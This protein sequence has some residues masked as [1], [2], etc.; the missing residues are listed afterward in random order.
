[1]STETLAG[2]GAHAWQNPAVTE[3]GANAW[4]VR[5]EGTS[6]A[7]LDV[8]G[9]FDVAIDDQPPVALNPLMERTVRPIPD[10]LADGQH[11]AVIRSDN[12][13]PGGF[14]VGRAAPLPWLWVLAPSLLLTVLVIVGALLGRA[15]IVGS[16]Q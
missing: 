10:G 6:F 13:P 4:R 14:L 5:F 15:V 3:A 16:R 12:G 11:V 2:V 7:L 8:R 1:M 9:P